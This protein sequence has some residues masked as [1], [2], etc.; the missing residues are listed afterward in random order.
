MKKKNI[1]KC[2]L[3]GEVKKLVE[4]HIIPAFFDSYMMPD[5]YMFRFKVEER[6]KP[7]PLQKGYTSKNILCGSCDNNSISNY[8]K[9]MS[10][11]YR[12]Y[13]GNRLFSKASFT[14]GSFI[15]YLINQDYHN[16]KLCL[17]SILWRAHISNNPF[18]ENIAI[19][20][21]EDILHKLLKNNSSETGNQFRF[22]FWGLTI[23]NFIS[24]FSINGLKILQVT[25]KPMHLKSEN[26]NYCCFI[27]AGVIIL[28]EL[29]Y[30][31]ESRIFEN[32]ITP[33]NPW[34]ILFM[35]PAE[36]NMFLSTIYKKDFFRTISSGAKK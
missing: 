34:R 12:N 4:S 33:N 3:C 11:F 20:E 7:F 14:N 27:I 5:R 9:V 19:P 35:N 8:E 2:K 29:E 24:P 32:A 17:L 23:Q 16:I 28:I 18:Y 1:G 13:F 22:I 6:E 36:S 31:H 10:T 21:Y 15:E 30:Y 26:D 25:L